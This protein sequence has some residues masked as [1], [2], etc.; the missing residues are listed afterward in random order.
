MICRWSV[1]PGW[2]SLSILLFASAALL[3][4]ATA[5]RARAQTPAFTALTNNLAVANTGLSELLGP[6]LLAGSTSCGSSSDGLCVSSAGSLDISIPAVTFDNSIETGITICERVGG[7]L[8]CNEA[9]Q[10]LSGTFVITGNTISVGLMGGLD[11]SQSDQ[12]SVDGVRARIATGPLADLGI[13]ANANLSVTPP[14]A[15]NLSTNFLT[16]SQS[17]DPLSLI[18]NAVPEVPCEPSD[19]RPVAQI[20]E[21]YA[22]AFVDHGDPAEITFPGAPPLSRPAFGAN[23]NSR[24]RRILTGMTG[25]MEGIQ[26]QWPASI[27]ALNSASILEFVSQSADG[28]SVTYVYSTQDQLA[29]DEVIEIFPLQ[30]SDSNFAFTGAEELS[31]LVGLQIQMFPDDSSGVVRPRFNHPPE[32]EAAELF[33]ILRRCSV[34]VGQAGT[35]R[36]DVSVD[37]LPW[38]GAINYQLT[39]PSVFNGTSVPAIN[40]G[41]KAGT[42]TITYLSGG[43]PG[44]HFVLY[45]PARTLNLAPTGSIQF[46]LNFSGLTM[47]TLS[48]DSTPG[49]ICP[50]PSAAVGPFSLV[51]TSTDTQI[52]PGGT[53]FNFTF[54]GPI[55]TSPEIMGLGNL[56]PEVAG[57]SMS[58]SLPASFS[59]DPGAQIDFGSALLDVSAAGPGDPITVLASFTPPGALTVLENQVV[60]SSIATVSC[61]TI[62][63]FTAT[64]VTN[65]ASFQQGAS[66]GAIITIFGTLLTDFA[67]IQL[68]SEL[69]L[70]TELGGTSVT[71]NGILAP[72]FAVASVD[73][74]EQINLQVPWE[75]ADEETVTILVHRDGES[76]EP[77]LVALQPAH[78]GIFLVGAKAAVL[79]GDDFSLV[80]DANPAAPGETVVVFATGLGPVSS[81]PATGAPALGDPLSVTSFAVSAGVGSSPASVIF[82]GLAPGFAGLYQINMTIPPGLPAGAHNI[83][84][85]V[86]DVLSPPAAIDVQ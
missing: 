66:P 9:G 40:E 16:L 46:T 73:E 76:S 51:N 85:N 64:G 71:V 82:S 14:S 57:A 31:G 1:R 53:T 18:V 45:S 55:V 25:M 65:A 6:I 86:N 13:S 29:S 78:P 30:L 4:C 21:V 84:I 83:L 72:L 56:T 19:A 37:G 75:V 74:Q 33:F 44:P 70:P 8:T 54:S 36:V 52:I 77:V 35:V 28:A 15:M 12:I 17:A 3:L 60:L 67:G 34:P 63:A 80:T 26:V 24:V 5:P 38:G 39:G 10:C 47:A 62:P 48:L 43:P 49:E 27:A 61:S 42:Y 11:I 50:S 69:P 68:A 22:K 58:F 59:M 23:G 32:P 81:T 7:L 41:L 79:H 2:G 20:R